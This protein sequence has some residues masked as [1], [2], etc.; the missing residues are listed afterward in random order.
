MNKSYILAVFIHL[1]LFAQGNITKEVEQIVT[2][3]EDTLRNASY[4]PKY[5]LLRIENSNLT[6]KVFIANCDKLKP[7]LEEGAPDSYIKLNGRWVLI[8]SE[9]TKVP[10]RQEAKRKFEADF[11]ENLR[12]EDTTA[13]EVTDFSLYP[14]MFLIKAGKVEMTRHTCGFPFPSMYDGGKTFDEQ[15]NLI[16]K[17]GVYDLCNVR[18]EGRL[19]AIAPM[20]FVREQTRDSLTSKNLLADLVV[21]EAGRVESVR[22]D[23]RDVGTLSENTKNELIKLIQGMSRCSRASVAGKPVKYRILV[24]L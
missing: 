8:Y 20:V 21:D 4:V 1:Q 2:T 12:E 9:R 6:K 18:L 10:E 22:L 3:Y 5:I 7:L 17:D 24:G 15:G 23:G 13:F 11:M 16:Y 19:F 14:F